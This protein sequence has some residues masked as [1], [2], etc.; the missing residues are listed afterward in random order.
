MEE[1]LQRVVLQTKYEGVLSLTETVEMEQVADIWMKLLQTLR[2][3][4][5]EEVLDTVLSLFYLGHVSTSFVKVIIM[6]L[7]K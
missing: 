3:G 2:D 6:K 5:M 4:N 1:T 7:L